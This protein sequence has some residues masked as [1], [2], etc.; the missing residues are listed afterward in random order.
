VE[1]LG[2]PWV[3]TTIS[4]RLFRLPLLAD[5]STETREFP[6]FQH[7]E[8]ASVPREDEPFKETAMRT[9]TYPILGLVL[10]ATLAASA[11][12]FG[13]EPA[14]PQP[15]PP[16]TQ[17][18]LTLRGAQRS[19]VDTVKATFLEHDHTQWDLLITGAKGRGQFTCEVRSS[20]RAALFDLQRSIMNAAEL[21]VN[22]ANGIPA[23]RGG[24]L[25]NMDDPNGGSF[26]LETR[27]PEGR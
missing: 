15:P 1:D 26:V 5:F 20:D 21:S 13:Q 19:L 12:A 14:P 22:C 17:L 16:K 10:A 7:I 11:L 27:R 9:F 18:I 2:R 25:I 8:L 4:W 24:V 3:P 6:T 23:P